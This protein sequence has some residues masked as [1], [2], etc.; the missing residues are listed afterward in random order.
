MVVTPG[1]AGDEP[2][3]QFSR[4][5]ARQAAVERIAA[6][7]RHRMSQEGIASIRGFADHVGMSW[8]PIDKLLNG[9]PNPG[10]R[11]VR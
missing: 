3:L 5:R 9:D 8:K 10:G 6:V 2:P 1:D 4:D 11:R 7:V